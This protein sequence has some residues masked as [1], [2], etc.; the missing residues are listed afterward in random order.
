MWRART[1]VSITQ[2]MQSGNNRGHAAIASVRFRHDYQP[3]AKQQYFEMASLDAGV[4][5]DHGV[6]SIEALVEIAAD[7]QLTLAEAHQD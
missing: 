3:F 1:F 5:F 4:A 7:E 6:A 2:N